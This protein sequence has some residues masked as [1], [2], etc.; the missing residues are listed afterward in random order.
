MYTYNLM[1]LDPTQTILT[2]THLLISLHHL[3]LNYFEQAIIC[4]VFSIIDIE[5]DQTILWFLI[6]K[7]KAAYT[8]LLIDRGID[9]ATT[10]RSKRRRRRR[11]AE[12]GKLRQILLVQIHESYEPFSQPLW[13]GH[14]HLLTLAPQEMETWTFWPP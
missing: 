1:S 12:D 6:N 3:P 11:K 2:R 5:F 13:C 8:L 10:R 7:G 9:K 14:D 4:V